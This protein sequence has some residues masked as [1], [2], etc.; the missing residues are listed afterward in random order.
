MDGKL[1]TRTFLLHPTYIRELFQEWE[2]A[3]EFRIIDQE[4]FAIIQE[5]FRTNFF[6]LSLG[7]M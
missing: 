6:L 5:S 3:Q 4:M 2:G 7:N 1:F